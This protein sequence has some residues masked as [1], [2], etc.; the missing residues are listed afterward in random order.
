MHVVATAGHVDHGKSTLVRALTGM[1]PDRWAEE[2][3][4]GMTIDLGYAWTQLP[5]GRTLAFVDVPGHHRFISNMLAGL[6]PSPA[7]VFVVAADEGWRRQSAE[8]LAAVDAL[9]VRHGLLVV[10]RA[11][12]ADP[13]AATDQALAQIAQTSLG[14]VRSV[15]CS[16]VTG[17]GIDDVRAA[18]DQLVA[19]LSPPQP[20]D[21]VRLWIDRAFTVRGAGT[22]VTGTLQAGSLRVGDEVQIASTGE[23]VR[24][25]GLESL[26]A[27]VQRA[28]AVARVAVNLRGVAVDALG[29]GDALLTVG[30]WRR[31]AQLDVRLRAAADDLPRELVL[32]IGAAAVPARVRPLGADTARLTLQNA[33]PLQNGDVA[34][35]RDPGEH[36]IA[37]GVVV[38]DAAPPALMRRRA[39]A[40]RAAVLED[41]GGT[42]DALA[43]VRRRGYVRGT[44]LAALGVAAAASIE[45]VREIGD[46]LVSEPQWAAWARAVS[47]VID[48]DEREL[49][50]SDGVPPD[51]VSAKAGIPERRILDALLADAVDVEMNR[52]R[53]RRKGR[54]PDLPPAVHEL[55]QQL[56]ADPFGA[57]RRDELAAAGLTAPMLR[58]AAA[59]GLLLWLGDDVVLIAASIGTA[60]DVL[61]KLPQPFSVGDATRALGTSRRVAV[62]LLEHLDRLG[63]TKRD[64]ATRTLREPR[65]AG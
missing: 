20:S 29:R 53:L 11:D 27:P 60:L 39:A 46:W 48:D 7:V 47:D 65:R 31:T 35:L 9:D 26:K 40:D 10:T 5:S 52:G 44:E 55:V 43:E 57:P 59:Q 6:G 24:I 22:V 14:Q 41:I 16:A 19:S 25:R 51:T 13:H 12:L 3:R 37:A 36:H 38:L 15:A 30:G 58:A 54:A 1:E 64:G 32:H 28:D 49:P 23:R 21:R 42:P 62:P 50:L 56:S 18:L 17:Q 33:L 63:H 34:L 45:G 4:R 2:R 61:G 8:H